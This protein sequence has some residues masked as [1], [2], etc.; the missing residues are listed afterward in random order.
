[1]NVDDWYTLK[2]VNEVITGKIVEVNPSF[3]R[4]KQGERTRAFNIGHVVSLHPVNEGGKRPEP[5]RM[6]I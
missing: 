1:M 6:P 2:T 4:I 3:F 5:H